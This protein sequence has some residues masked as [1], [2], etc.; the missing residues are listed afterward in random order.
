L[1]NVHI[2]AVLPKYGSLLPNMEISFYPSSGATR[3]SNFGWRI[4]GLGNR[5]SF[6]SA[7]RTLPLVAAP[8]RLTAVVLR[9]GCVASAIGFSRYPVWPDGFS[10]G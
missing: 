1:A 6:C 7:F 10:A 8:L 2:Q 5:D 4:A 9:G 3:S